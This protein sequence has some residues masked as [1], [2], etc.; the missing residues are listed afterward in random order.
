M[1]DGGIETGSMAFREAASKQAAIQLQSR[2]VRSCS[3]C[4]IFSQWNYALV[5]LQ[6]RTFAEG[7]VS[8]ISA[9]KASLI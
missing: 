6:V 3:L 2:T 4:L 1:T 9:L 8:C 7:H 5:L